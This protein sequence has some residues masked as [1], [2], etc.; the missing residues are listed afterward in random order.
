MGQL[1]NKRYF[2][3]A[4]RLGQMHLD[5]NAYCRSFDFWRCVSLAYLLTNNVGEATRAWENAKHYCPADCTPTVKH[6]FD[7]DLGYAYVRAGQ[8]EQA[9]ELADQVLKFAQSIADHNRI[10]VAYLLLMRIEYAKGN[11]PTALCHH[12]QAMQALI[13]ARTDVDRQWQMNVE[14]HGMLILA[15]LGTSWAAKDVASKVIAND[16]ATSRKAVALFIRANCGQS[17]H[18]KLAASVIDHLYR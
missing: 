6:D 16:P 14:F 18:L 1:I 9:E 2:K 12:A 8:I 7:R 15:R 3:T 10:A 4:V 11:Y 17:W 13:N 5:L